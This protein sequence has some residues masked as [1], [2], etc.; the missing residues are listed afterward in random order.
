MTIADT[1]KGFV[2]L[3]GLAGFVFGVVKFLEVQAVEAERP[4]LEKK[5]AW[6]EEAVETTSRIATSAQPS[7]KD[8]ERFRQMYWGV[9]GLIEKASITTAMVEFGKSL[10]SL[11]SPAE[12][13]KDLTEHLA[14]TRGKSLALA[15]ACRKELSAEWSPSWSISR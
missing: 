2:A 14:G 5:L 6:C 7:Q 4:Y 15:H 11:P 8:I 3:I 10:D 9:M 1:I 13:S 12:G